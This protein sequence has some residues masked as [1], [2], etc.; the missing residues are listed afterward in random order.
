[1]SSINFAGF[2][3]MPPVSKQTPL[4]TKPKG[5]DLDPFHSIVTR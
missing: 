5:F 4:P 2:K 1:M 3:D